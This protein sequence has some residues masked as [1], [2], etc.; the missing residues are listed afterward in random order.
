MEKSESQEADVTRGLP[1]SIP[2]LF[3]TPHLLGFPVT[4]AP[5][6]E[7]IG[8]GETLKRSQVRVVYTNKSTLFCASI[9][10]LLFSVYIHFLEQYSLKQAGRN[11]E[12]KKKHG[13]CP[14]MKLK[15][16]PFVSLPDI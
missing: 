13:E 8:A 16:Y 11:Q 4:P 12:V 6:M 14:E 15:I 2:S 3:S 1:V 9:R 7:W 10:D 5:P